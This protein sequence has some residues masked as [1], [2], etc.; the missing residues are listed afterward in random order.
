MSW[1]VIWLSVDGSHA[2]AVGDRSHLTGLVPTRI[3]RSLYSFSIVIWIL[4]ISTVSNSFGWT[5]PRPFLLLQ[6]RVTIAVIAS[7]IV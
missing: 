3:P 4:L 2:F 7:F 6:N 5:Y 1:R